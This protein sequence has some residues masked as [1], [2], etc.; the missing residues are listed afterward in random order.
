MQKLLPLLGAV[1]TG[2]LL[3]VACSEENPGALF[4]DQNGGPIGGNSGNAA[5][6]GSSSGGAAGAGGGSSGSGGNPAAGGAAGSGTSA[7]AGGQG[8]DGGV[9]SCSVDADCS[10]QNDCT[11]ESCQGGNCVATGAAP[12]GTPCGSTTNDACT[13]PD[14]CDGAGVCLP[15][16]APAAVGMPCG[17]STDDECTN[18]DTCDAEG[19]CQPNHADVGTRCGSDSDDECANPDVCGNG[20]CLANDADNGTACTGG[21]CAIGACVNGQP[22]GCP[23]DVL[24][25]VPANVSWSSVGRPDLFGGGCDSAGMPDYAL[26]FTA[27]QAGTYRFTVVGLVDSTPY[28][29]AGDPSGTPDGPPDGDALITVAEG[30]CAGPSATQVVCSD[31]AQ[32]ETLDLPLTDQQVITVYLNEHTQSGGGTGTLSIT[33]FP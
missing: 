13:D 14:S 20:V 27:P 23:I 33:R 3:A 16:H 31:E 15:N 1:G 21:S 2:L 17:S 29:G 9:G 30:S 7:G 25:S 28:T 26:V 5:S 19:V 6:G 32:A 12:L 18:P 10:D 24:D 8:P 11:L 22:V 4:P